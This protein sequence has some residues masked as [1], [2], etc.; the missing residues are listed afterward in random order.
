MSHNFLVQE[1][2]A[3]AVDKAGAARNGA[4]EEA[5]KKDGEV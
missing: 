4:E 1:E 2:T 3:H 5:E